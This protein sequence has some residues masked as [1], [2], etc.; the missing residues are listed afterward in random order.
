MRSP[1]NSPE[2]ASPDPSVPAP[3]DAEI[4]A[5]LLID[6]PDGA[7]RLLAKMSEAERMAQAAAYVA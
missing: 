6:N 1:P 5:D 7:L 3:H 2:S 4:F